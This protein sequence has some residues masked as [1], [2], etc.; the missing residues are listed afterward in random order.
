MTD[1]DL[2][3]F[4]KKCRMSGLKRTED[5]KTGVIFVKDNACKDKQFTMDK[6]DF[7]V[8]RSEEHLDAIYKEAGFTIVSK[9][10]QDRMPDELMPIVCWTL[11]PNY[12]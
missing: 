11:K 5:G 4:F 10:D 3:D 6:Q 9:F 12:N 8:M 7:S 1:S 2:V